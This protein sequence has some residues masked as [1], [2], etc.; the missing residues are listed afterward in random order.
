[1]IADLDSETKGWISWISMSSSKK[2]LLELQSL[3]IEEIESI[4]SLATQLKKDFFHPEAKKYS[5]GLL[6]T[7][8]PIALMFFEPST[9][10]RMSFETACARLH[11]PTLLLDGAAGTSLEKGESILDTLENVAAMLPQALVV[12]VG[13]EFDLQSFQHRCSIP[14]I[15]AGWGVQGHPTQALLDLFTILEHGISVDQ[16][17]ILFVGDVRHSR[18]V[19]SHLQLLKKWNVQM[20]ICAPAAFLPDDFPGQHFSQLQEGLSWCNVVMSLR[21]QTERH[22]QGLS[23]SPQDYHRDYGLH[24][25]SIQS[26]SASGWMMHPGPVMMGVDM[27]A[28]VARDPRSLILQQVQNGTFIRQAVLIHLLSKGRR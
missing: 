13:K 1:M 5:Q 17:R 21:G 16:L 4:F 18:V 28:D 8:Q 14:I 19:A 26:L 15:N 10:T 12:R 22:A 3:S 24:A 20:G 25:K 7:D 11:L 27:T 23:L 6:S 2:S 9:R